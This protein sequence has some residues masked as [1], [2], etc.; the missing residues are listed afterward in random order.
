MHVGRVAVGLV[1][2]PAWGNVL[3]GQAGHWGLAL[4][5]TFVP[6]DVYLICWELY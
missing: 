1:T 3:L 2:T 6:A 4:Q 5:L